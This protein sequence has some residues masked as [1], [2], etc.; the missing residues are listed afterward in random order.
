MNLKQAV[1]RTLLVIP[2]VDGA[3]LL[4][5]MLP[6]LRLPG[7]S[8]LVIDQGSTDGTVELCHRHGVGVLRTG[9]RLTYTQACNLGARLARA[10]GCAFLFVG[11]ND[12]AFLTD[13]VRECL[14]ELI[15][16][17]KLG[18][19][20][21]AQIVVDEAAGVN[22]HTYRVFWN[23]HHRVFQHDTRPPAPGTRRLEADFCE[24]T[25]AG[26][27]LSTVD[28]LGFLD[29]DFGFY[30]EDADFGFRLREAGYGCAYLPQSTIRHWT[31]STMGAG[32]PRQTYYS[33]RNKRLF[34][35][36]HVTRQVLHR[37]HGSAEVHSWARINRHLHRTLGEM[38]MINPACPELIFSHPGTR[39]LDHLF[40]VWETTRLPDRWLQY[41]R[42]YR[43]VMTTSRWGTQVLRQEG[44]ANAAYVP[45]GVESDVFSPWG[46]AARRYARRTFLWFAHNQ[47]RKGLDVMLAAW[48][49]FRRL[50]PLAH[51]V[52]MGTGVRAGVRHAPS[53]SYRSRHFE[54]SEFVEDGLS[55]YETIVPLSDEELAALY[56]GVDFTVCTSRSEGFGFVVAES[57]ACGRPAIF[58]DYGGTADF[59]YPGALTFGGRPVPANYADKGFG[60]VGNWWEPDVEG[61]VARLV[62]A[63]DMDAPRYAALS[64]AGVR[65]MRADFSWRN[66][67]FALRAA[68][69][70]AARAGEGPLPVP[71]PAPI[72]PTPISP[73]PAL[74]TSSPAAPVPACRFVGYVEGDLGLGQALRN[75]ILA[76]RSAG[77]PTS[78]YP[79]NTG[80]ETRRIGSFL[81]ELYDTSAPSP[82]DV[83]CVATEHVPRVLEAGVIGAGYTILRAYWELPKAPEAWRAC[84]ARV[85]EIWAPSTFV[86]EA[87]RGVFDRPIH[88]VPTAVEPGEGPRPGRAGFG[89]EEDRF[90]FLYSFDY[91]S[92]PHRKN[93]LALLWAFRQAFP[94]GTE[95]VGLVL[96]SIG[97]AAAY[98]DVQQEIEAALA[99]DPR[100][101]RLDGSLGRED[102]LGLIG[103]ADAYVSLH[104][105][106]GF[107]I[108]M[109]EAMMMGKIVIGT[110]FAGSRDFLSER[111]GFPV[112]YAL[113]RVRPEEYAF[114]HGQVWAEP[115]TAEAARIMRAVVERPEEAHR[116]AREGARAIVARFGREAVGRAIRQRL[117]EIGPGLAAR[118]APFR[119]MPAAA[120]QP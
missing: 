42:L 19:V 115:S 71:E 80:I 86:A 82:V 20:A 62:E 102:M 106:E 15:A 66:T 39:P 78:I 110:D 118:G 12:I 46:E 60:D 111:T 91:Y 23:L 21:P 93:P 83:I 33:T 59:R 26:L 54:I 88:I 31:S 58:G 117:A 116:R 9:E 24:L 65:A 36:K 77:V 72:S 108:G 57:L 73:A 81:P 99:A 4:E 51:L 96:K 3:H 2:S 92:S 98:P 37:D 105:S 104:R 35:E 113:R 94:I 75:D 53:F 120:T 89:M 43:T 85:D 7:S 25:L 40:T 18:I 6:T 55:I 14:A 17:P 29:D 64:A 70:R 47:H 27:R 30:H 44:F 1:D 11:N 56:R 22:V 76:A 49:D 101:L 61:L 95:K 34:V 103:A 5:R 109:A 67:G 10:R 52:V 8:V 100:I 50:R 97:P 79:F 45:L 87:F 28:E 114:A 16:D 63:Y 119:A 38:G 69:E 107:G 41:G 84:L 48:A 32:S 112:P 74:A 13:V 90:Y 68:L